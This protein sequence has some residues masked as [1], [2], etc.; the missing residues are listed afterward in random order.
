MLDE[1][2]DGLCLLS[3]IVFREFAAS[4]GPSPTY[5]CLQNETL[6]VLFSFSAL[7]GILVEGGRAILGSIAFACIAFSV[8]VCIVL[9]HDG[10]L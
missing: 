7:I 10:R 3:D 9:E 5:G 6:S 1:I 8:R 4:I 2:L